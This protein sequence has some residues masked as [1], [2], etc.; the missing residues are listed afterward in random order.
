MPKFEAYGHIAYAESK[1]SCNDTKDHQP[2]A[3]N[4]P[5]TIY[6][7]YFCEGKNAVWQY[8]DGKILWSEG[9]CLIRIEGKWCWTNPVESFT[10]ET[11]HDMLE[12]GVLHE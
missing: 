6:G 4:S 5:H 2:H 11:I 8:K 10:D 1:M 3:W 9:R 12:G 7:P